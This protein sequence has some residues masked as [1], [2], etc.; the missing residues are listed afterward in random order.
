[1]TALPQFFIFSTG[2]AGST[3]LQAVLDAH[4]NIRIPT[5]GRIYIHLRA[6]YAK[7]RP[8]MWPSFISDTITEPKINHFWKLEVA[9]LLESKP[10][11]SSFQEAVQRLSKSSFSPFDHKNTEIIGD[12]NPINAY[13]ISELLALY[14]DAKLIHLVR[15]CDDFVRSAEKINVA[16]SKSFLAVRWLEENRMIR[17]YVRQ[18]PTQ[19]ITIQYE[20]LIKDPETQVCKIC[21][22]LNVAYDSHMLLFYQKVRLHYDEIM[23]KLGNHHPLHMEVSMHLAGLMHPIKATQKICRE[24]RVYQEFTTAYQS[25][26]SCNSSK[27]LIYRHFLTFLWFYFYW[28]K[29]HIFFNLMGFKFRTKFWKIKPY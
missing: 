9:E 21:E 10:F 19:S 20:E 4:P 25:S 6:K 11:P 1:M 28:A 29:I 7:W 5:E 12:K 15:N 27:F 13:F 23:N 2:S 14:P 3:L 8:Q 18:Y 17:K 26:P 16:Q 24:A 22:F